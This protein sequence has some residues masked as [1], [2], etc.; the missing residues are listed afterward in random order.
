MRSL[1]LPLC[2]R[3]VSTLL[4]LFC[5]ASTFSPWI[6]CIKETPPLLYIAY[7]E[8]HQVASP[9]MVFKVITAR[10]CCNLYICYITGAGESY[11]RHN[12]PQTGIL[13]IMLNHN[14]S[15]KY[16]M[17]KLALKW[18]NVTGLLM[19]SAILIICS[20]HPIY[21]PG[22]DLDKTILPKPLLQ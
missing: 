17:S 8:F 3:A 11:T 18:R 20:W 5:S 9:D 10:V 19:Y 2:L 6:S 13:T 12:L 4:H 15:R 1:L 7:Q 16:F 22:H 14:L 21:Q